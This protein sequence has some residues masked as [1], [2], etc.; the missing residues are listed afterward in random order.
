[1]TPSSDPVPDGTAHFVWNV[2]SD[3]NPA[4]T[5]RVDL[6]SMGGAGECSCTDWATRRGPAI[7]AGMKPGTRETCCK[8][9]VKVRAFFLQNLLTE[10]AR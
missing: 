7:K 3:R 10:L 9:V 8:H 6:L 2:P 5:Y 4:R 1:M